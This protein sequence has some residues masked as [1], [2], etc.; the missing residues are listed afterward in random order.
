MKR[1]TLMLLSLCML[2]IANAQ[3]KKT[4][5]IAKRTLKQVMEVAMPGETGVDGS[6]G[7]SVAYNPIAKKYY[8]PMLGN[9][10]YPMVI[11]NL[12]GK[13]LSKA[14][15][16]NDMRGLWYNPKTKSVEGN[17][18]D[19]GGWVRYK[20]NPKGD[21]VFD[22]TE[23]DD[24]YESDYIFQNDMRQPDN[25]AVGFFSSQDNMVYFLIENGVSIYNMK[26]V[27][28]KTFELLKA[29]DDDPL[30]FLGEDSPYNNSLIFTGVPK[31][32]IGVLNLYD[33][34]IELYN[35]A[36]GVLSAEWQLPDDVGVYPMFN[37]SYA[38]G[39]VWLFNKELRKWVVFK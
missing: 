28:K 21:M 13:Q 31:A 10:V 19:S 24:T 32:E 7:G 8:I 22:M 2:T 3:V 12:K 17:C 16:G 29:K 36:T 1:I 27:E 26:G 18:Y 35:K 9:A 39:M 11:F 20:L 33:K 38:N 15:A 4:P 6:N 23:V 14:I 25:Q 37:F 5:G 34:K 30:V